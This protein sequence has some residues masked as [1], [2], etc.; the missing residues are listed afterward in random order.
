MK[1]VQSYCYN[2]SPIITYNDLT[3]NMVKQE[4]LV[5]TR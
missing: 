5:L 4:E 3:A 2:T 1:D